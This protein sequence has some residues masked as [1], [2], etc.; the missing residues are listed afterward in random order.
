MNVCKKLPCWSTGDLYPI[1]ALQHSYKKKTA[2][3]KSKKTELGS[4]KEPENMKYW[5]NQYLGF[6]ACSVRAIHCARVPWQR[7][8]HRPLP[9]W[10]TCIAN[11][12]EVKQAYLT[13]KDW[14]EQCGTL[15]QLPRTI[16]NFIKRQWW[17][18][19]RKHWQKGHSDSIILHTRSEIS[20]K[21]IQISSPKRS[22]VLHR[23]HLLLKD[24]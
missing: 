1:Y 11:K 9:A 14:R 19:L 20:N 2:K 13:R 7:G 8:L 4:V 18:T 21:I 17:K 10:N 23:L 16:A 6:T 24:R 5:V 3:K 22:P 15:P 12:A